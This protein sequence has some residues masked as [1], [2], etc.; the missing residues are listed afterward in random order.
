MKKIPPAFQYYPKDFISDDKVAPMNLKEVGAYWLLLSYCWTENGLKNDQDYL[1]GLCKN[2]SEWEQIWKK[3]SKCFYS[4]KNKNNRLFNRRLDEERKKQNE[5]KEKMTESGKIG[6][7]KRW[8]GHRQV[9]E[10]GKS[11]SISKSIR[12]N[13]FLGSKRKISKN[14]EN[15]D[16]SEENENSQA[17][18]KKW[19][20]HKK[21]IG[22]DASSSLSSSSNNKNKILIKA[23]IEKEFSDFWE[24][25]P[26][27][28]K[29]EDAR[30]AFNALRKKIDLETI[31]KA[32]NGYMDF[33]KDKRIKENFPQ[34]PMYP[35][36]FLREERWK[37]YVDFRYIPKL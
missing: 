22:S 14:N 33:L 15:G 5:F 13:G 29:K 17:I 8:G 36:T 27:K 10:K 25:Y 24:A 1:K 4:K 23:N 12:N 18:N 37:D 7:E 28:L 2:D 31:I 19:G 34:N 20:G 16:F 6:A 30:A 26:V 35:A 9:E 21:T 32:F 3:I 11:K